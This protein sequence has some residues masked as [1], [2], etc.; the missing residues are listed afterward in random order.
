MTIAFP[1]PVFREYVLSNFDRDKDGVISQDE[2]ASV[3]ALM[4]NKSTF[5][6]DIYSL[7]GVQYFANLNELHY[8]N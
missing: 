5:K 8:R 1:D 2:A 6:K 7:E 4:L 3:S